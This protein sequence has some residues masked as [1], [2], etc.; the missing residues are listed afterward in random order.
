MNEK[1]SL[2]F[3]IHH[4]S[5]AFLFLTVPHA[6]VQLLYNRLNEAG[7]KINQ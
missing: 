1:M 4:Q 7:K 6:F 3:L 2:L 5:L